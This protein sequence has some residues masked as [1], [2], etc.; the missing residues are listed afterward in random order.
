[1]FL[2]IAVQ[3]L[4]EQAL[5]RKTGQCCMTCEGKLQGFKRDRLA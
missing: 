5:E 3:G 1:V 4:Y 2:E